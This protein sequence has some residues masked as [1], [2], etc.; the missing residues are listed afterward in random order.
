MA[1]REALTMVHERHTDDSW[2]YGWA[3]RWYGR[4]MMIP[5]DRYGIGDTEHG[6][7]ASRGLVKR[8]I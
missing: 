1:E 6:A 3:S 7:G 8:S 2:R 4:D 5:N